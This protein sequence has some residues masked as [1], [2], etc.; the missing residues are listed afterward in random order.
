[1]PF[2]WWETQSILGELKSPIKV[3]ASLSHSHSSLKQALEPNFMGLSAKRYTT[4]LF[5]QLFFTG[6]HTK[7]LNFSRYLKRFCLKQATKGQVKSNPYS[8]ISVHQWI[9]HW[10]ISNQLSSIS[11]L[12]LNATG[13]WSVWIRLNV[14]T[15]WH[16]AH[17]KYLLKF[18]LLNKYLNKFIFIE[19]TQRSGNQLICPECTLLLDISLNEE[20]CPVQDMACLVFIVIWNENRLK[21]MPWLSEQSV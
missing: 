8:C 13:Y 6:K 19:Q 10:N 15:S 18:I 7:S 17:D 5:S 3:I 2:T 1:M 11:N 14:C 21:M 9:T 16:F 12:Q 4:L 20:V